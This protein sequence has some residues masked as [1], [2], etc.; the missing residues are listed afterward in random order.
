MNYRCVHRPASV[1][2]ATRSD[3]PPDCDAL[4]PEDEERLA[5]VSR[6]LRAHLASRRGPGQ[7]PIAGEF[8][9]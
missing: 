1:L 7:S 3:D 8:D 5:R 2:A 6:R 9:A 4:T